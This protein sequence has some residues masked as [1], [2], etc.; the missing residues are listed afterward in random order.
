MGE[1]VVPTEGQ[2][3]AEGR[4]VAGAVRGAAWLSLSQLGLNALSVPAM[5]YI[6]HRL[7]A[8]P[9]AHWMTGTSLLTVAMVVTNL[10]LRSAFVRRVSADREG[11]R[12]ALGDQLGLRLALTLAASAA[13][14][15]VCVALRYPAT[16]LWCAV[17]GSVGLMLTTIATTLGDVLQAFQR[18]RTLS[19]VG[20]VAGLS[21]TGASVVAAW[22]VDGS[23]SAW[24]AARVAAA[25]LAGPAVSVLVLAR[26][27]RR[28]VCPIVVR[29]GVD[30][31]RVLIGHSRHIA[32]QQLLFAGSGHAEALLSPR[33]L[34][35]NQ[36]GVLTAGSLLANRLGV[37]P[38]SLCTAAFPTLV[39]GMKDGARHAAG[40]VRNYILVAAFA[41]IGVA[42]MG[43]LL[44]MPI[45]RIL[46][47]DQPETLAWVVRVTIWSLPLAALEL[48]MGYALLA[49]GKES[50]QA[51]LAMP[52]SALGL[53][54]S[55]VLISTFGLQGACWSMLCRPAIRGLFLA[56]VL[57][58]TFWLGEDVRAGVLPGVSALRKAG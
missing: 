17:I 28:E 5:G 29:F 7:G 48:V 37:L 11:V 3:K 55:V 4:S 40:L 8:E 42:I 12:E 50:I 18:I 44:A 25:Y 9:Y 10:G 52:A 34:G 14:L 23:E 15:L 19:M 51:R 32:L 33:L 27:V 39:R 22:G 6:I 38:D 16:V 20:I 31:W 13:V 53:L 58:R 36:F 1:T 21:L 56:P 41:G 45:A 24:G 26:L 47:P 30:R 57:V 54:A 49:A 46:L 2:R 35:M 43:T